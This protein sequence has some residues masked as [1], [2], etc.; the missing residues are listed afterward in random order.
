MRS[1]ALIAALALTT[2]APAP[3]FAQQ[4]AT[5]AAP[6]PTRLAAGRDLLSAAL[7]ESGVFNNGINETFTALAPRVRADW[8]TK[9]FYAGLPSAKKEALIAYFGRLGP[10]ASE[11]LR[12]VTPGLLDA[13]APEMATLFTEEESRDI[14]TFLRSPE[15]RAIFTRGV[16]RGVAEQATGAAQAPAAMSE[17]ETR[18]STAFGETAGGRA[19]TA[20]TAEFSA[21][22]VRTVQLGF[23]AIT[24][25][26]RT[27][28]AKDVCGILGDQCPSDLRAAAQ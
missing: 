16:S 18:A 17:A 14:A 3:A 20:K 13:S 9:P 5:Q 25:A 4:V 8:E 15:G 1:L 28:M 10:I 2:L 26:F 21:L 27:R 22:L 19:M 7:V 6:S 23:V 24:P 11:L 12:P